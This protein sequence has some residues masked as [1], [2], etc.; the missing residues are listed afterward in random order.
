MKEKCL[1]FI[2]LLA[3]AARGYASS[4]QVSTGSVL[5]G[6]VAAVNSIGIKVKRPPQTL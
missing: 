4:V 3:A 5:S 2:L 1:I 6:Q